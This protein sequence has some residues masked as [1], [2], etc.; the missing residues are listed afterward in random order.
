M[1]QTVLDGVTLGYQGLWGRRRELCGVR[2]QVHALEG[3]HVDAPLL[4][5]SLHDAWSEHN[6]SLL[7]RPTSAGLLHG[8]L[9]ALQPE[10][11]WL[12]VQADWCEDADIV[13]A[14][15]G[16]AQ[17][18][19]GLIWHGPGGHTGPNSDDALF[20]H[21]LLSL[22]SAQA[23]GA[24]HCARTGIE[25]SPVQSGQIYEHMPSRALAEHALDQRG[26]W[27][28]A[29]WP[30]D[31]VLLE[32]RHLQVQPGHPIVERLLRAIDQDQSLEVIEH[33]LCE[34]PLL[35]YRFLSHANSG[36]LGLRQSVESLHHGLMMIGY[37]ALRRWLQE[38]QPHA[39]LDRNLR[40]LM[41][42]MVLRARLMAHLLGASDEADLQREIYLCGLFSQLD[43][44]LDEPLGQALQRLPLSDRIHQA[45]VEG[46]G[47]YHPF[48]SLARRLEGQAGPA[49]LQDC[50]DHGMQLS[51][52][53]LAL[54]RTLTSITIAASA[55][56]PR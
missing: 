47:P 44:L 17:R 38:Q 18:G 2:L 33:L 22:D 39:S 3:R 19:A 37:S 1:G 43:L 11:P 28:L 48:L 42:S 53:H 9:L 15:R 12:E 32:H 45:C 23:L 20:A 5:R 34:D 51:D 30:C 55:R 50:I 14:A 25:G 10:S 6:P 35:A 21:R 16:A 26:V 13:A 41:Q 56:L 46:C 27:A 36:R 52:V 4:L 54:L 7:L 40:P 29:G 24:L 49:L 8:L 31:D